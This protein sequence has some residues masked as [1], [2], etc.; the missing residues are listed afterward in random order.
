MIF[1][2][3]ATVF[4]VPLSVT[5][6]PLCEHNAVV[7]TTQGVVSATFRTMEFCGRFLWVPMKTKFLMRLGAGDGL[8]GMLIAAT[9]PPPPHLQC[10]C[11]N[12]Q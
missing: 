6:R 12:R 8:L 2:S 1:A 4:V 10:G 9:L 3:Q 5:P 7:R 11:A